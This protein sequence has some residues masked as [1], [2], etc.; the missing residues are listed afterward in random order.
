MRRCAHKLGWTRKQ[1]WW[2]HLPTIICSGL[3][4][5]PSLPGGG[6]YPTRFLVCKGLARRECISQT[7]SGLFASC[8]YVTWLKCWLLKAL[9]WSSSM[10]LAVHQAESSSRMTSVTSNTHL[11][12]WSDLNHRLCVSPLHTGD[13]CPTGDAICVG[14]LKWRSLCSWAHWRPLCLSAVDV[15]ISWLGSTRD[16]N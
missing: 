10:D 2:T 15:V 3:S 13:M 12:H 5:H 8:S 11:T 6:C 14:S 1:K 4:I 7:L 16:A 9:G